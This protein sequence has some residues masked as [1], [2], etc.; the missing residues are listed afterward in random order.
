MEQ[1][2]VVHEIQPGN[3]FFADV[4]SVGGCEEELTESHVV[5]DRKVQEVLVIEDVPHAL[6]GEDHVTAGKM[7]LVL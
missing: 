1:H 6:S 5:D 4:S 2:R 3:P 7:R